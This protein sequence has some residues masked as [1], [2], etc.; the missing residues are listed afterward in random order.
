MDTRVKK[1]T[2]AVQ[3]P[4]EQ[5]LCE[6]HSKWRQNG[7]HNLLRI[8]V[9]SYNNHNIREHIHTKHYYYYY[10]YY[11]KVLT[12]LTLTNCRFGEFQRYCKKNQFNSWCS[13][14]SAKNTFELLGCEEKIF[15]KHKLLIGFHSLVI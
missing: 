7:L 14:S 2:C 10:Y 1:R 3:Q 15:A 13:L 5:E 9:S 12:I 4:E 6:L 11:M 8:H